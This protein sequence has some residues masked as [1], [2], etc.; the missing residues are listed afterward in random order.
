M[1]A[2]PQTLDAGA[3]AA[4]SVAPATPP[5]RI[6]GWLLRRELWENRS[7]YLA[8]LLIAGVILFGFLIS[9]RHLVGR[10]RDIL[11]APVTEQ[12]HLLFRPFSIAAA[13]VLITG[14]VVSA[15]YCLEALQGERRD[16]SILFWKSLPVS[17]RM[18]VLSKAL[19]PLAVMP[20]IVCV[21]VLATQLILFLAG[22]AVLSTS[23][24]E[25]ATFWVRVPVLQQAP[26]M[27]YGL[28]TLTLWYAPLYAWIL[29][30]SGWA[31]RMTIFW[32]LLPSLVIAILEKI[33]FGTSA[34]IALMHYRLVGSYLEAFSPSAQRGGPIDPLTQLEPLHFLATP[35]LWG[36][37]VVAAGFLA[38]AVWQR[39]RREPI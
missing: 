34:F 21:T 14:V 37:L 32:I 22:G 35:G 17:D 12:A 19:V 11:A 36:G 33:A 2:D 29:L 7:L 15:F 3:P 9:A 10:V 25:L 18:T 8:P 31:R 26:V 30:V 6:L 28:V 5:A 13:L 23:D 27:I 4:P 16:R 20:A 38:T 24:P 39:R 1:S